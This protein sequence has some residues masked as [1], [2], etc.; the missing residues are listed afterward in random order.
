M[1]ATDTSSSKGSLCSV[2]E[3]GCGARS[4]IGAQS[5]A[6]TPSLHKEL[7]EVAWASDLCLLLLA[8]K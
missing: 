8:S 5:T 3:P 6:A 4:F 1:P 2:V 7:A